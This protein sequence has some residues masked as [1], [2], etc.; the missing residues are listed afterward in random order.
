MLTEQQKYN[1]SLPKYWVVQI[2][3]NYYNNKDWGLLLKYINSFSYGSIKWY[4]N[5]HICYGFDGYTAYQNPVLLTLDRF[6]TLLNSPEMPKYTVEYC[7]RNDITV[8]PIS[9]EQWSLLD[10]SYF[11]INVKQNYDNYLYFC[12]DYST[13]IPIYNSK[14]ICITFEQFAQDN[15]I[16]LDNMKNKELKISLEKAKELYSNSSKEIK[17]IF[18]STFGKEAFEEKEIRSWED[19][20]Y[21]LGVENDFAYYVSYDSDI[22]CTDFT[23]ENGVKMDKRDKNCVLTESAAKSVLAFSQLTVIIAAINKKFADKGQNTCS[24]IIDPLGELSITTHRSLV[25]QDLKFINGDAC[26]YFI[27][28]PEFV[29]LYKTYLNVI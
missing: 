14:S 16:K 27:S 15:N 6:I 29:E 20:I 18:E 22:I 26:R 10:S 7:M 19:A 3:D 1:N 8:G 28:I 17:E 11:L 5:G 25:Q 9:K 13:G 21:Y 24:L 23:E 2:P 12:A 4:D